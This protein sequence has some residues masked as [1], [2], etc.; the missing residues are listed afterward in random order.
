MLVHSLQVVPFI[1]QGHILTY[2]GLLEAQLYV[3][4]HGGGGEFKNVFSWL[5]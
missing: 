5:F 4:P 2:D 3:T 1:S